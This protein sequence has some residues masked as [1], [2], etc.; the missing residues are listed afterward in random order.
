M[1]LVDLVANVFRCLI[2]AS[3]FIIFILQV[4]KAAGSVRGWKQGVIYN[5]IVASE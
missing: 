2:S 5:A 3:S 1:C 4:K